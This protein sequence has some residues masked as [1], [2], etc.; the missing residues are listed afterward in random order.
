MKIPKSFLPI[1]SIKCKKGGY[2]THRAE[3]K[4][5]PFIYKVFRE[6]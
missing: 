6:K 4:K 1:L 5:M 3:N 2:L